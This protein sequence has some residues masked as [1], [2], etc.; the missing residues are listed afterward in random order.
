MR[1]AAVMLLF[2]LLL[3][4][5][6]SPRHAP[7]PS[8]V[9]VLEAMQTAMV[10]TA[11]TLPDGIIRHRAV[12]MEDPAYLTDTFLSALYGEAAR[13]LLDGDEHEGGAVGD[14][15]LFLSV[16]PYPCELAVFRCSDVRTASA[17][18]TICRGRLD[19]VAGGYDDSEWA[20]VAGNGAVTAEGCFVFLVIAE[21]P[22]R[23]IERAVRCVR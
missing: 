1:R 21:D 6:C 5:G 19:T 18:A 7:P 15:A 8:A 11:Q 17:V 13:G 2:L 16:M 10:D 23:V 4:S 9:S 14:A 22:R 3:F 20:A 12:P